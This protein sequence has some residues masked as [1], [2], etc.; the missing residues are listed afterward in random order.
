[1]QGTKKYLFSVFCFL[2]SVFCF[3]SS[4]GAEE[5]KEIAA[6]EV[7]GNRRMSTAAILAQVK[8]RVGDRLSPLVIRE[9]VERLYGL[10]YFSDIKVEVID[11]EE[12]VK[13]TFIVEEEFFIKEINLKGVRALRERTLR[14]VLVLAPG[15]FFDERLS[16]EDEERIISLYEEKG[17]YLIEVEREV[18]RF[19][20]E[21]EVVINIIIE[22]GI[23]VRVGGINIEGNDFF[24]DRRIKGVMA[25]RL[26]RFWRRGVFNEEVFQ[27]DLERI[28]SFYR[29]QG[30]LK[31]EIVDTER[32]LDELRGRI[33]LT[34]RMEEGPQFKVGRI[35][36]ERNVLFSDREI[37]GDLRMREGDIFSPAGLRRDVR[38]VKIFYA[39]R[40]HIL[41]EV[42]E[43]VDV[44]EEEREVD[45]TYRITEGWLVYVEKID[46]RGNVKTRDDVL[47][48]ELTIK[49]GD[50]FDARKIERSRERLHRLGFF[51]EVSFHT[52]P[53]TLPQRKNLV[54]EVSERRTGAFMFGFGYGAVDGLMGFVELSQSNFDIRN[55]PT[56]TG[57]GQKV[58]LR[59]Q[60]G[61]ERTEYDL[62]FT[63]PWLFDRP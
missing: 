25:T 12:A 54:F 34:I 27:G 14:E 44:R 16:S 41:A 23:K 50:V 60:L 3:L 18:V 37:K 51:Y 20:E 32:R 49:P 42:R 48:R 63:E 39:H 8:T 35:S 61:E 28:T 4:V 30:F 6:L 45:I 10:G 59:A 40:G 57:G 24:P 43:R 33:Y 21:R 11:Y 13:V 17:F 38:R 5:G 62:S 7:S 52:T 58:R 9:D 26:D 2:F 19:E 29:D 47:R 1:M 36:V 22:E 55:P 31:A 46:I 53:G 56:F 15:D